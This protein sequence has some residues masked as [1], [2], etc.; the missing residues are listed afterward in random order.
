[1]FVQ[2]CPN[3]VSVSQVDDYL[4]IWSLIKKLPDLL[5]LFIDKAAHEDVSDDLKWTS[6]SISKIA[7]LKKLMRKKKRRV[8]LQCNS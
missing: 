5:C 3:Y 1:M 4:E 6:N 7:A 8:V 2:L